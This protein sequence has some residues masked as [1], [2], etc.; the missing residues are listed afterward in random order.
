MVSFQDFRDNDFRTI[1]SSR[2]NQPPWRFVNEP[3]KNVL[4]FVAD[5]F[6]AHTLALCVSYFFCLVVF[7]FFVLHGLL[8]YLLLLLWTTIHYCETLY[9]NVNSFIVTWR[10]THHAIINMGIEERLIAN[11][12]RRQSLMKCGKTG[13]IIMPITQPKLSATARSALF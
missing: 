10:T 2:R 1:D 5:L 7:I 13:R 8:F 9:T 6:A 11:C 3:A 4:S 12:K